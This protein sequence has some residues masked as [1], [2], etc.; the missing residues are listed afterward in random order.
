[1]GYEAGT[2]A[3]RKILIYRQQ[4]ERERETQ[5]QSQRQRENWV[6]EVKPPS[7]TLPPT[8]SYLVILPKQLHQSGDQTVKYHLW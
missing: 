1:M 6:W 3:V 5:R 7:E 2:V 8:R 4:V